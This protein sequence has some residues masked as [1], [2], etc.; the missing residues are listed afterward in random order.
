MIGSP[1]RPDGE[2]PPPAKRQQTK[3]STA[4]SLA[5]Q[6]F[7]TSTNSGSGP[8]VFCSSVPA[9]V[10]VPG[11]TVNP[12]N[13]QFGNVERGHPSA[14]QTVTITSTGTANLV[15]GGIALNGGD[16]AHFATAHDAA[17]NQTLPP[18]ASA[19][20]D[21]TFAPT[22]A[23]AKASS[24]RIPSNAPASPTLV[25]LAGT[26]IEI[27]AITVSHGN[28]A[29]GSF[30]HGQ[31][32]PATTLTITSSGTAPLQIQNVQLQGADPGEFRI[33]NDQASGQTIAVGNTRT[34]DVVFESTSTDAKA[35]TLVITS[36]A[37]TS[38]TS[39]PL[40]GTGTELITVHTRQQY[41]NSCWAC[42]TRV[43]NAYYDATL[44]L[45]NRMNFGNDRALSDH[46]GFHHNQMRNVQNALDHADIKLYSGQD[47]S[48]NIPTLQEIRDA[49]V[50]DQQPLIVCVTQRQV[51]PGVN[52]VA[53]D[54][55]HYVVIVGVT[56]GGDLRV[57]DPDQMNNALVTVPYHLTEYGH[58]PHGYPVRYWGATY[59]T[60]DAI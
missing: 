6:S 52:I 30:R 19:T 48:S 10:L 50:R 22:A 4:N 16:H 17:S 20:I 5:Q 35:A 37:P 47:D 26:G 57:M 40:T 38:P 46:L 54:L 9:P 1:Q 28:V 2:P 8:I 39:V 32:S 44:A 42:C 51:A 31:P 12:T 49:V 3:Y 56:R 23:G 33:Q 55:G 21:V 11:I 18:S 43:V 36:N 34:V 60:E 24:L 7:S 58:R 45:G 29:F 53:A 59:Y 27:P 25:A 13:L 14:G 15:L 41:A